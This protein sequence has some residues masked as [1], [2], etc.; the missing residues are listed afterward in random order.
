LKTELD[1]GAVPLTSTISISPSLVMWDLARHE[2]VC[3][4]MLMRGGNL[5][6]TGR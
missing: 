1:S 3:C 4:G 2:R 6:S 5:G